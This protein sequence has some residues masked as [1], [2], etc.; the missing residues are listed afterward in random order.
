[1]A[2]IYIGYSAVAWLI[3]V[4]VTLGIASPVMHLYLDNIIL[5]GSAYSVNILRHKNWGAAA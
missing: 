3:W 4:V 5:R 2:P 1:M